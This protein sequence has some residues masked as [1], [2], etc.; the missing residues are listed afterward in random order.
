M[1][2]LDRSPLSTHAAT[3]IS[4]EIDF[5]SSREL[6]QFL[7]ESFNYGESLQL[8]FDQKIK[9][10]A[11]L[12]QLSQPGEVY[13]QLLELREIKEAVIDHSIEKI[14]KDFVKSGSK[15]FDFFKR[16]EIEIR[17]AGRQMGGDPELVELAIGD[18]TDGILDLGTF[19]EKCNPKTFGQTAWSKKDQTIQKIRT[20]RARRSLK[21]TSSSKQFQSLKERINRRSTG[22]NRFRLVSP[23]GA[24]V[25][26]VTGSILFY[27]DSGKPGNVTGYT[28]P[29]GV[30]SLTFDDGPGTTTSG[31]ILD[32]LKKYG[33]QATFFVLSEKLLSQPE[34]SIRALNEDHELA[35]HSYTHANIPKIDEASR[36][37]EIGGALEVFNDV[38]GFRP[39][40]F[41]LPYGS[42]VSIASV[43]E[44]IKKENLIHVFWTVDTLD[45]QDKDPESIYRRTLLQMKNVG[46]QG[47]ILFHDIHPQTVL[48]S[49]KVMK[50]L[51]DPVNKTCTAGVHFVVDYMNDLSIGNQRDPI[52]K[53][54]Q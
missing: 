30:W 1:A 53:I 8:E 20:L 42:G 23:N 52:C 10:G 4:K 31:Q 16:A 29:K 47:I 5:S 7:T 22:L 32:D 37:K 28:Y 50:Y 48:A 13:A 38:L 54:A 41:R 49:E 6:V 36:K 14:S 39:K 21:F 45:W 9:A 2:R 35:S 34:M 43:R 40:L 44:L 3:T 24:P 25:P 17:E 12:E 51:K 19:A 15:D 11:S 27:P 46:N 26:P 18:L 33:I